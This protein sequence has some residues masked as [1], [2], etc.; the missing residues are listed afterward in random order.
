FAHYFAGI[1]QQL[2]FNPDIKTHNMPET[3][4]DLMK[5]NCLATTAQ[6]VWRLEG[7]DGPVDIRVEGQLLTNSSEVVREAVLAGMGI[8]LRSTW[9]VG[10]ELKKGL[11][12]IILPEYHV[13]ARVGIYAVFPSREFL[14]VKVRLFIDYLAGIYGQNPYWEEGLDLSRLSQ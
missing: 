4:D 14:P 9:D 11:L 10:P 1:C 6:D 5:H 2:A 7:P 12:K 8:A 13:G 3:L